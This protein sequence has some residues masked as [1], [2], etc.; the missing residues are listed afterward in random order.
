MRFTRHAREQPSIN[1]MPLLDI[2]FLVLMFLVL[3]ATFR[4]TFAL[5]LALPAASTGIPASTTAPGVIRIVVTADG[6]V[7]VAG[8]LTTLG[9]LE[10]RLL[11][12]PDPDRVGVIV[13]ADARSPH[14]DVVGV[15][16]TIRRAGIFG[17]RLEITPDDRS[18]R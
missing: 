1:L 11:A 7:L 16:D 5:D 15:M 9:D 2:L 14:G 18:G 4:G 12:L 8:A 6:Q 10:R 17:L 13:S 3:T